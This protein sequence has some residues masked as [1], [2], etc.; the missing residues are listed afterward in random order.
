MNKVYVKDYGILPNGEE[1]C[2]EKLDKLFKETPDNSEVIFEE[3]NYKVYHCLKIENKK[4]FIFNG[5][6]AN[7]EAY[8]DPTSWED[9]SRGLL[10]FEGCENLQVKHLSISTSR[11]T[12]VAGKI[13]SINE[14]NATF[15][16]ELLEGCSLNGDEILMA[17]NS[18]DEDL[19]PDYKIV[20][21]GPSKY[22][23][24]DNGLVEVIMPPSV[25]GQIKNARLGMTIVYRHTMY[26]TTVFDF[27]GCKDTF[28][29]DIR[30][31]EAPGIV[32]FAGG[33]GK[34]IT[35]SRYVIKPREGREYLLGANADGIHVNAMN[36]K[37]TLKDSYWAQLGDD[38]LNV[39]SMSC[40]ITEVNMDEG[41]IE[42]K[43]FSH[44]RIN[45]KMRD[46][47]CQE[48][49]K[50]FVYDRNTYFEVAHF[51]VKKRDGD[52]LYFQ[53]LDGELKIGDNPVNDEMFPDVHIDNC[54][55]KN[56]RARAFLLR[57]R[58]VVLE[59]CHIYGMSLAAFLCALDLVRWGEV[60]ASKNVVIRNNVI[61]KC[62]FVNS[63]VNYG[64]INIRV[65][66]D[67][68]GLGDS[69]PGVHKDF[70]IEGNKIINC[71]AS[72]VAA[73]AVDNIKIINNIFEGNGKATTDV[74]L[75]TKEYDIVLHNC[76][77]ITIEGNVSD[78]TE[79]K[80]VRF[81]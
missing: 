53:D 45:E 4:N 54:T 10:L 32:S 80:K 48:G 11:R 17:A 13:V 27:I 68:P 73:T 77:N 33:R 72:A 62:G 52:R 58:N 12:C 35:Y 2:W 25:A 44:A 31:Y 74:M 29:D 70:V 42:A 22:K 60:A 19:S 63:H 49:D 16:M 76:A 36:G 28:I 9:N 56:T 20:T 66:D 67:Q 55:V 71:G 34:N 38:A 5:N 79:D 21:Y 57:T 43:D 6:G 30:I 3:G 41:Y 65:N 64:A 59:N 15:Q 39:H 47:W 78:K 7:F 61:E 50:I 1:C 8:Y 14:E 23:V 26:G 51:T 75:D 40:V 24:L 37:F 69:I 18:L 81:S 46:A